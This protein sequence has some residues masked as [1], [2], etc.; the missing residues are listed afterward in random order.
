M[1]DYITIKGIHYDSNGYKFEYDNLFYG[2]NI[3]NIDIKPPVEIK[4][5]HGLIRANDEY[6]NMIRKVF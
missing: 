3:I 2:N 5:E 6:K 4:I 1:N